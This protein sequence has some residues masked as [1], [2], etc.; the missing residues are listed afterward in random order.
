MSNISVNTEYN[1][2]TATVNSPLPE[3]EYPKRRAP[4]AG[5][6]AIDFSVCAGKSRVD[7]EIA[8]KLSAGDGPDASG[9]RPK[10][11][12]FSSS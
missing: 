4:F 1:E 10:G 6:I 12:E 2:L 11:E 9:R 7:A 5:R 3:S 8:E